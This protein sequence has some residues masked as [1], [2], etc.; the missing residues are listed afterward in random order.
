MAIKIFCDGCGRDDNVDTAPTWVHVQLPLHEVDHGLDLMEA[1]KRARKGNYEEKMYCSVFCAGMSLL[2]V[3][4]LE[5]VGG[6][7]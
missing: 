5:R 4:T 2:G 6:E 3:S 7:G 1:I